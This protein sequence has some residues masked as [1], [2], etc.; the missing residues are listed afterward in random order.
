MRTVVLVVLLL[1]VLVAQS[2]YVVMRE[3]QPRCFRVEVPQD[4]V[5]L[6]EF[7]SEPWN[8]SWQLGS[9]N[10]ISPPTQNGQETHAEVFRRT[11][12]GLEVTVK[13]PF[14]AIVHQRTYSPNGKMVTT[15]P[16]GGEYSVCF[17]TNT[18]TWWSPVLFKMNVA[19]HTGAL[20][21]DYSALAKKEH[22]SDL[23]VKVQR[24]FDRAQG[25]RS[26]LAY[27]KEREKVFRNTSESTNSR[28]AVW[29]VVQ[30]LIV[31]AAA[32]VQMQSLKG[33]FRKKKLI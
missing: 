17:Q 27:Q 10:P 1:H 5:I 22:L 26:E 14:E 16:L 32:I 11:N 19:I 2:L 24:L 21:K 25:I 28:A 12:L 18:T 29:S 13:N 20:A 15:S 8:D 7:S 23:Q 9:S 6:A 31:I 33:F 30:T 4:T 3:G